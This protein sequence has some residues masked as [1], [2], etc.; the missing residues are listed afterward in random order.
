MSDD[1]A[2]RKVRAKLDKALEANRNDEAIKLL[3][4]IAQFEP[5]N[6]RWPHKRG[7][8]LRKLN[9]NAEA[10]ECY[11]TA[12]DIYATTGFI[13]RAIAMAKTVL[14]LDASRIDILERVDPSAAAQL[15]GRGRPGIG[16]AATKHPMLL[17]ESDVAGPPPPHQPK[18]PVEQSLG[19]VPT[20]A[21]KRHP[22][23][24]DEP[25]APATLP[26]SAPRRHP[27]VLDDAEPP[28]GAP[29]VTLQGGPPKR[30]PMV[31][32][33]AGAPAVTLQGRP[34]KPHS[35]GV[36]ESP[37]IPPPPPRTPGAP[38][39]PPPPVPAAARTGAK[40]PPPPPLPGAVRPATPIVAKP[41]PVTLDR[42]SLP[43]GAS[44]RAPSLAPEPEI[45]VA[46]IYSRALEG[47]DELSVD[48]AAPANETRFSDTPADHGVDVELS[49]EELA[50]RSSGLVLASDPEP[51]PAET[52][53]KLP[54][55]PLFA[56]V[57]KDALAQMVAGSELIELEHGS[58]VLRRGDPGDAL[59]GI[60]EGSVEIAGPTAESKLILAEGDVFG[61]SCLLQ[62][63]P[64]HAD[65]VVQ[66]K[67]SVLRVPRDVLVQLIQT[68][69]P[70]AELLLELLTRRLL[71]NLLQ[72]SLLF[73]EFD[74]AG[75]RELGRLF[76]IR[77][78]PADTMLAVLGK[79]MDGLYISLTGTLAINQ[80][81]APE[82]I[83][84]PGS[85][86]GQNT[87]LTQQ[88]SQVDVKTRVNMIVLRLPAA[89][90]TRVAMQYPTMLE[91]VAE[92]S[93]SEVVRVTL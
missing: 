82:R 73:Q 32:D 1:K 45:D 77:R 11:A 2:L 37:P 64:S 23:I 80:P 13:A 93:T 63:E 59:Y 76:E 12:V 9:R 41:R 30:H 65:V 83:A 74:A 19:S 88:P 27:M 6:A 86:F 91:R 17:D 38:R 40:P 69:P 67:L 78:A 81:G 52:L 29:A 49:Q 43:P 33:E 71:G 50:P 10:V 72:S 61:E 92:L 26:G 48:P 5:S 16:S 35:M 36:D 28:A 42:L 8:L 18:L 31:V 68:H 85:M 51:P 56:E 54:L 66:G 4:E 47:I 25:E 79:K 14:S 21:T 58:L 60:V 39:P 3:V 84:P 15:R 7:D 90:F 46:D 62:D 44:S 70:L 87:L 53:A 55:F 75:R 57:A 89:Q 34:A 20:M 22:M 24:L